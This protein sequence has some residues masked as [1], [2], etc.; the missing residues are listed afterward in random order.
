M[1]SILFTDIGKYLKKYLGSFPNV[2]FSISRNTVFDFVISLN[3]MR[4]IGGGEDCL[5]F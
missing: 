3:K 4:H 2:S 5:D 1:D